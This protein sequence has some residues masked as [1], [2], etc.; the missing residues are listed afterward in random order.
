MTEVLPIISNYGFEK[1][2]LNRIEGFV[3]TDNLNCK[4][5]MSK[6]DFVNEGIKNYRIKNETPISVDIYAK[7][8]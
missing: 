3:E 8:N 5:A 4:K 1:I 2:K 7:T 6:L